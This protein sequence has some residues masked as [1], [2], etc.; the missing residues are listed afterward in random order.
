VQKKPYEIRI[1]V[2]LQTV[3]HEGFLKKTEDSAITLDQ[4][5]YEYAVRAK[6]ATAGIVFQLFTQG[7]VSVKFADCVE[8]LELLDPGDKL[9]GP[10]SMQ[11]YEEFLTRSRR[12]GIELFN[13][14]T[15]SIIFPELE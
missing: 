3:D 6:G 2:T 5:L 4:K 14:S 10:E 9:S 7:K 13:K 12:A 1:R 15:Q 11:L 8:R